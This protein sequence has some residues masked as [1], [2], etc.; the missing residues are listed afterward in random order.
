MLLI[1]RVDP[2]KVDLEDFIAMKLLPRDFIV[3]LFIRVT[4]EGFTGHFNRVSNFSPLQFPFGLPH[5]VCGT[6]TWDTKEGPY[7]RMATIMVMAWRLMMAHCGR[8]RVPIAQ[9]P[10][11]GAASQGNERWFMVATLARPPNSE[12]L[13]PG[14]EVTL[15]T[16]TLLLRIISGA[17]TRGAW[18]MTRW[19]PTCLRREFLLLART[20][21]LLG[22]AVV[23]MRSEE[24]VHLAELMSCRSTTPPMVK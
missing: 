3:P 23:T 5:L 24:A 8:R 2:K 6:L 9:R 16:C 11:R 22:G 4:I 1:T 10:M 15:V 19:G 14:C 13:R 20:C 7:A 12:D 18:S 17:I 21:P